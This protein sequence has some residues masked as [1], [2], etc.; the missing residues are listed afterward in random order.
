MKH[1]T[2]QMQ[3]TIATKLHKAKIASGRTYDDLSAESLVSRD[4]TQHVMLGSRT[5]SRD[6]LRDI[7]MALIPWLRLNKRETRWLNL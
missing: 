3:R 4:H 6:T 5:G 7:A 1:P 2:T